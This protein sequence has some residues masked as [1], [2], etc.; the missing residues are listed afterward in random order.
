[1]D[2]IAGE[3]PTPP[4]WSGRLGLEWAFRLV[5]EPKRLFSRYMVEPWYILGLLCADHAKR[6]FQFRRGVREA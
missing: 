5:H 1:M 2:Y 6:T 4:R 3:V